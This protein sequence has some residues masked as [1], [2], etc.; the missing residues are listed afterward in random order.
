MPFENE[1]GRIAYKDYCLPK[2]EIKEYNV[3]I[4]SKNFFDQPIHNDTKTYENIRNGDIGQEG[5]YTTGCLLDYLCY[6]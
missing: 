2:V 5:Y 4:D 3:K 1:N 6:K